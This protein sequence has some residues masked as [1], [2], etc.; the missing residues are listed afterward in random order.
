M[1]QILVPCGF[2]R[3]SVKAVKNFTFYLSTHPSTL[4]EMRKAMKS[5]EDEA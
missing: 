2:S 5:F 4:N 1:K 3:A